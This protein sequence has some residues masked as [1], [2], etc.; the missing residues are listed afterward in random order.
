MALYKNREV[1]VIGPNPMANT[2][3]SINIR[4]VDGSHENVALSQV[5]FTED[6]KKALVKAH[7]SQYDNVRIIKDADLHAIRSGGAPSEHTQTTP[8][9]SPLQKLKAL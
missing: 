5:S 9:P 8:A 1:T 3:I 2:P 4:Y 7:P 6:E